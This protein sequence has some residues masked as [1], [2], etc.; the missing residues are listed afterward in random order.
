MTAQ[1]YEEAAALRERLVGVRRDLHR[2]PELGFRETRTAGIVAA[3]LTGLGYEVATGI[4]TTGVIGLLEG[5]QP[6]P[7]VMLRFDMD[8]LPV[9]EETGAEYA[10]ENP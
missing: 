5:G 6:G 10:S 9:T 2:H 1:I 3:E 7:A 4:A 8:A